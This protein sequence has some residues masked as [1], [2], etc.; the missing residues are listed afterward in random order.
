MYAACKHD[1]L[2]NG[3]T[4]AP[5]F[6]PAVGRG[7]RQRRQRGA[8]NGRPALLWCERGEDRNQRSPLPREPNAKISES[9]PQQCFFMHSIFKWEHRSFVVEGQRASAVKFAHRS[10]SASQAGDIEKLWIVL[11]TFLSWLSLNLR[12]C[13]GIPQNTFYCTTPIWFGSGFIILSFI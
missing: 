1:T 3:L 12:I 4:L 7:A 10:F 2:T 6:P 11:Y 9:S 5:C 8:V 13:A